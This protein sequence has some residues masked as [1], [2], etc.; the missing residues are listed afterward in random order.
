MW[1]AL[2]L[3]V[4]AWNFAKKWKAI[5]VPLGVVLLVALLALGIYGKGRHD[6]AAKAAREAAAAQA[7]LDVI[8]TKATA[9]SASER[10]A[11]S[12]R[13]NTQLQTMKEAIDAQP[14]VTPSDAALALDCERL[15]NAGYV[16]TKIPA[17]GRFAAT[18]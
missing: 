12:A 16:L 2:E 15:R 1:T 7:K 4:G 11:D 10:A 5:L 6:N 9:R 8:V 13:I 18:R 17:C 3:A 14:D